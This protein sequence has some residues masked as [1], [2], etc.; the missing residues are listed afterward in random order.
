[1]LAV[2]AVPAC[3]A[4]AQT[5]ACDD[6]KAVLAARIES[7]GVRGYSLETVPAG[8]PVPS[9]AKVIGTCESS[10]FKILYRRWG[11]AGASSGA[12]SAARAASEAQAGTVPDAQPRRAPGARAERGA[13]PAQPA[14]APGLA[15]AAVSRTNEGASAVAPAAPEPVR[16]PAGNSGEVARVRSIDSPTVVPPAPVSTEAAADPAAPLA[17]R[18]ADFAAGR[19]PWIGALALVVLLGGTWLWRTYFSAYDKDGLPRGPRL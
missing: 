18:A 19:W 14:S 2:S 4:Q 13:S 10:A 16:P 6:F 9:G 11:A 17:Q 12:A 5:S 1:M 3:S 15:P 8:V 7:T